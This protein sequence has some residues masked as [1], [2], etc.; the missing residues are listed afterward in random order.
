[1]TKTDIA[2]KAATL[3]VGIGTT[4]IAHSIIK[5]NVSTETITTSVTVP[6]ASFVIGS[7]AVDATSRYTERQIDAVV[8]WW[9]L[10]V[11]K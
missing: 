4:H 9:K 8:S 7:M 5:N 2:K 10:N 11:K 6:I 3:V 1:M